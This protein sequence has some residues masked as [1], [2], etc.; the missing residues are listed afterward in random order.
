MQVDNQWQGCQRQKK[1]CLPKI[2]T[3]SKE[4]L[5]RIKYDLLKA[6]NM[7]VDSFRSGQYFGLDSEFFKLLRLYADHLDEETMR[8]LLDHHCEL[9][10]PTHAKWLEALQDM[11]NI[12]YVPQQ[13]KPFVRLL[14]IEKLSQC[15]ASCRAYQ[16]DEVIRHGL[17]RYLGE[18]YMDDLSVKEAGIGLLLETARHTRS[19]CFHQI[20]DAIEAAVWKAN[21]DRIRCLA[22]RG[23]ASLLKATFVSYPMTDLRAFQAIVAASRNHKSPLCATV[24][25]LL[26]AVRANSK[27]QMQWH[28]SVTRSSGFLYCSHALPSRC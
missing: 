5:R 19:E 6:V 24:L 1:L 21:D 7:V 23:I 3:S 15:I 18:V 9:T 22:M 14:T 20:I 25:Y 16:D 13:Q 11:M 28:D 4:S 8:L 27:Y 10:Y 26:W 17:L 12:F 2:L